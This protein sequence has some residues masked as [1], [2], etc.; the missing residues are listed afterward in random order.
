M[1]WQSDTRY[2]KGVG[3]QKA[4]LLK[5]LGIATIYDLLTYFP[6]DYVDRSRLKLIAQITDQ[7]IT[8]IQAIVISQQEFFTRKRRRLLKI[9]LS[10]GT[11]KVNLVC[12]N[13]YYLR[14]YLTKGKT[15][16]VNGKFSR[17]ANRRNVFDLTNFTYEVLSGEHD[18]LIHTG[19]I[20]P[21]YSICRDLNMRF[22]R[23]L[24]RKTLDN[25]EKEIREF[26]P[27]SILAKENLIDYRLALEQVHFP[28]DLAQLVQAR[29][30]L[31][32]NEFFLLEIALASK[33]YRQRHQNKGIP[34]EI[35]KNLLAP[36]KELLPFTF[37]PEQKKV[38]REIFQDMQSP[39]P[40]NRLLQGDV[41]SGKTIVALCAMLLAVENGYQAVLMAPTEILAQQHY[42]YLQHFLDQLAVN[43]VILT[44]GTNKKDHKTKEAI[45]SGQAQ[46]IVG[47]QALLEED[48][49]FKNLGLI[50]IDEQHKFGVS[51]RARLRT[52][53]ANVDVIVMTATP[54]PRSLAL[55]LYG[56]LDVST[57]Q[58]LPPGRLPVKTS[59][60]SEDDAYNFIRRQVGQGRQAYIVYP[61][62]EE[63]PNFTFKAAGQMA[64]HLQREIFP[65]FTV[66]LLHGRLKIEEKAQ[67]MKDFVEGKI[68]ILVATTVIE[69]GIDV[70]NASVIL[71]EHA[72]RF[73]L[74]TLHQ[75]RG[76]VG[77]NREQA[78]CL[79]TAI[80]KTPEAKKRSQAMLDTNDGFKI[81]EYDLQIRGPGELGGLRQ[82]GL[83]DFK[84]A[85]IVKDFSLLQS[86]RKIAFDL[87]KDDLYLRQEENK[88]LRQMMTESFGKKLDL[89]SV[90]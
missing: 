4:K 60:P 87:I 50:I 36:F 61:L 39:R 43:Q 77:R 75:L 89:I 34:Y 72:E 27:R 15:V 67:V 20:V 48:V 29:R 45:A 59:A 28:S 53:G 37:T 81:A 5:D 54:I 44:G 38:I 16:V 82:H 41:G 71:I 84:I 42:F 32:F 30:R 9:V 52:K 2:L 10:D 25:F 40:M 7:E 14:D 57:I 6:R 70:A 74:S 13:Q 55:T 19:R 1:D 24:I 8:S 12:F 58:Q 33:Y 35:R 47:T 68:D 49:N 17:L 83:P 73:G 78:F 88:L 66:G 65:E 18:D 76:R 62:V 26:L 22:L 21:I 90:G 86:A 80:G 56:D 63:S 23:A 31:V 64:E 3:P 79:M 85:D 69:V 51:Q 11:G 46:I